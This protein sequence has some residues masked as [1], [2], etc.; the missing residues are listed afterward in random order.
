MPDLRG[1][2]DP[3]GHRGGAQNPAALTEPY[4]PDDQQASA[5]R[6]QVSL[7][8]P[9]VTVGLSATTRT[10]TGRFTFPSTS[11]ADLLRLSGSEDG[12]VSSSV[13]V[14]APDE[15]TGSVTSGGF[16]GS[17]STYT[18]HFVAAF[19]RS[20]ASYGVFDDAGLHPG[21]AV[22]SGTEATACGGWV[23]FEALA[24][25]TVTMKVGVSYVSV[26]DAEG[27]SCP[28][29]PRRPPASP[30]HRQRGGSSSRRRR[31]RRPSPARPRPSR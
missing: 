13:R 24:E 21:T 10:G 19:D 6:Y 30:S 12:I 4:T 18:L 1:R 17:Q 9:A 23:T 16:C 5:G 28:G 29:G 14:V 3:P 11:D 25:R 7:G 26:H 20:F 2:P 31:A 27:P 8:T 15:V 22:C